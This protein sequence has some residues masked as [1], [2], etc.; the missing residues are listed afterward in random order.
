MNK[1]IKDTAYIAIIVTIVIGMTVS[2]NNAIQDQRELFYQTMS[3]ADVLDEHYANKQDPVEAVANYFEY[4]NNANKEAL[5]EHSDSPFIF[6]IGNEKNAYD[7]YGDS[8][9]FEGLEKIGW[10]YSSIHSSEL[11]YKDSSSAMVHI[12]FSRFNKDDEAISTSDVT[13]LLV[14]KD[15]QWKMKAGFVQGNLTMGK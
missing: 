10:S 11:V 6:I 7:K 4:F 13:Y 1:Y 8:V 12:N 15:G 14:Y 5:N 2:K 3:A 9:D